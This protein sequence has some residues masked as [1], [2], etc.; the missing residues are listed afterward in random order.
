[1][2]FQITR[3]IY[4]TLR[5]NIQRRIELKV[6]SSESPFEMQAGFK[7]SFQVCSISLVHNLKSSFIKLFVISLHFIFSP[8]NLLFDSLKIQ[9]FR[10]YYY[11]EFS[12][13]QIS[14]CTIRILRGKSYCI[15]KNQT[16]G[17]GLF[18]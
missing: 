7:N 3:S 8:H 11:K 13:I 9:M 2:F 12:F 15:L 14:L 1:M 18:Y 10:L 17:R 5:R 6:Y 4:S 16:A